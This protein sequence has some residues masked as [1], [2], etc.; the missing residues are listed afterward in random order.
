MQTLNDENVTQV[1]QNLFKNAFGLAIE[2]D[3]G[4]VKSSIDKI[5]KCNSA[6]QYDEQVQHDQNMV[7]QTIDQFSRNVAEMMKTRYGQLTK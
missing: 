7:N 6:D 1:C 2:T 3:I 4:I 5:A